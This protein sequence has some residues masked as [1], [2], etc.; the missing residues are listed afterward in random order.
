M[1]YKARKLSVHSAALSE[2]GSRQFSYGCCIQLCNK[3]SELLRDVLSHADGGYANN[4][5]TK[6]TVLYRI[7]GR[8][9]QICI[10]M[11]FW[12]NVLTTKFFKM[13]KC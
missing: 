4:P 1:A 12:Q 8:M 2:P 5:F 7:E 9:M 10:C 11:A 6:V 3:T 13:S